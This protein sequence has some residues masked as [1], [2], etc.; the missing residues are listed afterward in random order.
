[1]SD[2]LISVRMM[3]VS[4]G[5][6]DREHWRQATGLASLPIE[7][8]EVET[9]AEAAQLL[10]RAGV[11][12]LLLDAEF[13]EPQRSAVV[14]AA[15]TSR[16]RP[17]VVVCAAEDTDAAGI[18]GDGV[19][20]K[21][22]SVA[23]AQYLIDRILRARVP[24]RVL[25]VDD[26]STMRSIVRKILSATRFP[27]DIAEA[28]EGAAALERLRGDS[29]DIIFLDYNMPGLNG[30]DTLAEIKREH[31]RLEVVMI[32]STQDEAVA[33]RVRAAGAAAF[34]KKPFF[35]ADIDA[36]LHAFC[37]MRPIPV[38]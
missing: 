12:V 21:P 18:D 37:G 30:L 11:D 9:V 35:P 16:A 36:V 22:S 14:R 27:L 13:P 19:I 31:P 10:S 33:T 3:I 34:L 26:S 1:M 32:T 20:T 8:A 17:V 7:A 25:I 23:E 38:V 24:S 6:P 5:S 4:K 2:D 29:F 15:R 28:E